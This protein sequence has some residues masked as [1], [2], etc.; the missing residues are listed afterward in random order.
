MSDSNV[1]GNDASTTIALRLLTERDLPAY[2]ALRDAMLA[3]HEQAFTSDAET[4]RARE[5]SSYR[6]RLHPQAGGKSLFTLGAWQGERLVG[7]LTCEHEGRQKVRHIA[8]L[9][10]MMVDDGF[11]GRGIGKRLLEQALALLRREPRLETV[12]LSV[13]A[14]NRPAIALYR[15]AGFT[16][17]GHLPRAIRLSD[18]RYCAKDLMSL[19]LRP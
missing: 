19:D 11:S 18:G 16:R 8:H 14:G 3:R 10:G 5:A 13:T 12:T 4:E 1:S 6:V 15:Q 9:I 2:K 17:Y 7:A